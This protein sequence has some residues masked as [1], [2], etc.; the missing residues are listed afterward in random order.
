ML[1][2]CSLCLAVSVA[3]MSW[4]GTH[5]MFVIELFIRIMHLWSPYRGLFE[6]IMSLIAMMLF[7]TEKLYCYRYNMFGLQPPRRPQSV[8]TTEN[9]ISVTHSIMQSLKYSAHLLLWECPINCQENFT[10]L[11]KISSVQNDDRSTTSRQWLAEMCRNWIPLWTS[12]ISVIWSKTILTMF[13]KGLY[14]ID[15]LLFGVVGKL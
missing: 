15:L 7:Q 12:R 4:T 8:W 3:I 6:Y 9:V 2:S 5:R 10:Y 1:V 13:T 14:I 11:L